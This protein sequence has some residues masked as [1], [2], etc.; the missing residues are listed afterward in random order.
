MR[1][2]NWCVGLGLVMLLGSCGDRARSVPG[3]FR[4]SLVHPRDQELGAGLVGT[5]GVDL[6]GFRRL[7]AHP[8]AAGGQGDRRYWVADRELLRA[9]DVRR[10]EVYYQ[11]P[12]VLSREQFEEAIR[13][14]RERNP[15][16]TNLTYEEYSKTPQQRRASIYLTFTGEGKERFAEVTRTN[17]GRQLAIV[18]EDLVITAPIVRDEITAGTAQI[19]GHFTESDAQAIVARIHGRP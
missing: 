17:I 11:E 19:S 12:V 2:L 13:Q 4:I 6:G 8:R 14:H 10:A 18:V 16:E 7:E 3:S 15:G 5:N 1:L 9:A